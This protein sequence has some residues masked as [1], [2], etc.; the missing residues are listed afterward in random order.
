MQIMGVYLHD[1]HCPAEH[2]LL[3]C[4][5]HLTLLVIPT[6]EGSITPKAGSLVSRDDPECLGTSQLK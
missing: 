6:K 5:T 3:Y 4:F 2:V 1:Q